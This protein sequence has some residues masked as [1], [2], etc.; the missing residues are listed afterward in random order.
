MDRLGVG[1]GG[2]SKDSRQTI[3]RQWTTLV[4]AGKRRRAK[5]GPIDLARMKEVGIGVRFKEKK[6][7]QVETKAT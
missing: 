1:T 5:K 7:N 4:D 6:K 3:V 2:F